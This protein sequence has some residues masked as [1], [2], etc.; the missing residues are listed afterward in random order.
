MMEASWGVKRIMDL[1]SEQ[2]IEKVIGVCGASVSHD[3]YLYSS[4]DDCMKEGF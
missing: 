2:L 1:E 4:S 3:S